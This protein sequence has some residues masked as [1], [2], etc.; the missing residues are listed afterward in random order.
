MENLILNLNKTEQHFGPK[1]LLGL[2]KNVPLAR[3]G[4]QLV[5]QQTGH[6]S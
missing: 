4:N 2:S 3:S 1:K 5:F 6:W